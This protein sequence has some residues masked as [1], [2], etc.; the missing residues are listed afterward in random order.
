MSFIVRNK[1]LKKA[2]MAPGEASALG[3]PLPCR[4]PFSAPDPA[5][6]RL[7][8]HLNDPTAWAY[9]RGINRRD[10]IARG[11]PECAE[12]GLRASR[13]DGKRDPGINPPLAANEDESARRVA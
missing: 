6:L 3:L 1:A 2:R 10:H 12:D 9:A 7:R 8:P 4:E 11:G 5:R 13:I